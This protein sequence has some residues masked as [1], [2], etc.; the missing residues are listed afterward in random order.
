M[1]AEM[2]V[3][4]W[5]IPP[6]DKLDS[7][8]YRKID[9]EEYIRTIKTFLLQLI[10]EFLDMRGSVKNSDMYAW[11]M[12]YLKEDADYMAGVAFESQGTG[13]DVCNVYSCPIYFHDYSNALLEDFEH[14]VEIWRSRKYKRAKGYD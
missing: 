7:D 3:N 2:Y 11:K 8:L 12:E 10:R 4:R 6:P 13:L 14:T 5:T 9:T 1:Y